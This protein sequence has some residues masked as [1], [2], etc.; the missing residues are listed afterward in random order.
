[1]CPPKGGSEASVSKEPDRDKQLDGDGIDLT[2]ARLIRPRDQ[3]HGHPV[4]GVV[5]TL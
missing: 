3:G 2:S 1:V 4:F 5:E